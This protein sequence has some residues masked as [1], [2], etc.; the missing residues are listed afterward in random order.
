MIF[1]IIKY[2]YQNIRGPRT[3]KLELHENVCSTET[4]TSPQDTKL[5]VITISFRF[6]DNKLRTQHF[7][8]IMVGDFNT[9]GIGWKCGMS[10]PNCHYYSELKGDAIYTS[11]CLLNHSQCIN[12]AGSVNRLDLIIYNFSVL[13]ITLPTLEL[14]SLKNYH[15]PFVIDIYLLFV[16]RFKITSIPTLNLR[17]ETIPYQMTFFRL[18]IGIVCMIPPLSMLQ[19]P[20]SMRLSKML[21]N[22]QFP[23]ASSQSQNSHTGFLF[24]QGTTIENNCFYMHFK[25]KKSDSL[26]N[27]LSIYGKL[28]KASVKSSRIRWFKSIDDNS[29]SQP[30]QVAS[31]RKDYSTTIQLKVYGEHFVESWKAADKFAKYFQSVYNIPCPD[32][33]PT[34]FVIF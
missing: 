26:Y 18:L 21:W 32:V 28:V 24:L 3:R 33:F 22:R 1:F 31:L 19:S 2:N 9:P 7:R 16:I 30:N 34:P 4:I 5:K 27:T 10:P 20:A 15:P 23:L 12:T 11:T 17:Q 29:K 6:S 14:S 13:C 8:V 25:N